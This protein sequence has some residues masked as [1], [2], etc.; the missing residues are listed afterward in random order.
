MVLEPCALDPFFFLMMKMA[1]ID[2]IRNSTASI[3]SSK[4]V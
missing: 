1:M 4:N 2:A 3:D